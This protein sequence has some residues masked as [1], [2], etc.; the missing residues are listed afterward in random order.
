VVCDATQGKCLGKARIP[1]AHS[2]TIL[3]AWKPLNPLDRRQSVDRDVADTKTI[4]S[5]RAIRDLC[6]AQELQARPCVTAEI[7]SA[8]NRL[9]AERAGGDAIQLEVVCVDALGNDVLIQ[10]AL[11]PGVATLYAHLM[12]TT[13]NGAPNGTEM[14]RIP[15]PRELLGMSFGEMLDYFSTQRRSHRTASIPIGVCRASQVFVNPSDEKLGRLQ[16][17]DALFMITER[18]TKG[19]LPAPAAAHAAGA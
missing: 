9:E 6:A 11:N 13:G 15:V 18:K 19:K 8:S 7:R 16:E 3:S 17:G 1:F 14:S 12:S 2:V 5:L 4:Q 10:S